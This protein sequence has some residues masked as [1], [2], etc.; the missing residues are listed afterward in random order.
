MVHMKTLEWHVMEPNEQNI[1]LPNFTRYDEID[2]TVRRDMLE[3][4][5]HVLRFGR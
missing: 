2:V 5:R 3:N 4:H 1:E